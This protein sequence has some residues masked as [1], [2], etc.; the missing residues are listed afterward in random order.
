MG[1]AYRVNGA[2]RTA[3]AAKEV[4]LSGGAVNSPQLLQLSGVGPGN[5]LGRQGIEVVHELPGV[6]GNLQDHYQIRIIN[7]THR[8]ITANDDL[9]RLDRKLV[10]GLKYVL[11]RSGAMTIGAGQV[12]IFARTRPELETPDVQYHYIPFAASA[13]G[14]GLLPFSAFTFSVCQLRPESRGTVHIRSGDPGRPPA[15]QP[16]YLD[17][18]TDRRAAIDGVGLGRKICASEAI[19]PLIKEEHLP[20]PA[21]QS[22]DEILD[23]CR[24]NGVTIFHPVGT[25]KM[26]PASDRGAVV[27]EKLRVHGIGGLRV[28]DCAIMPT[29]VSGNTNAAAIMIG[30]KVAD[31][32][33]NG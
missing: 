26:G 8:P 25:C 4:V 14:E 32:V 33:L 30:E 28:A 22:D 7:K 24:H 12:G 31:M 6:G 1:V 29:L 13:P 20:G 11:F 2:A 16:N 19:R 9:T 10:N 18:E 21:V 5:V 23:H 3:T 17:S 15:I 27:D